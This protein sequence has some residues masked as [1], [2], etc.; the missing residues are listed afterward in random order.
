MLQNFMNVI[1]GQINTV[2]RLPP[3]PYSVQR[4]AANDVISMTSPEIP[5]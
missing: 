3:P 1:K 5:A 4:D 2:S